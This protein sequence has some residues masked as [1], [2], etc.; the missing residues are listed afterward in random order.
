MPTQSEKIR[1]ILSEKN[2]RI[3]D[4]Y[5][6]IQSLEIQILDLSAANEALGVLATAQGIE[7]KRLRGA[8]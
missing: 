4:L 8:P 2:M 5:S 7:I 1:A 6:R 3:G